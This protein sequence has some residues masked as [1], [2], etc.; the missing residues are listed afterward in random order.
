[1]KR[2]LAVLFTVLLVCGFVSAQETEY[3]SSSEGLQIAP[4]LTF[5]I[6]G[7]EPN[8]IIGKNHFESRFGLAV[9][10]GSGSEDYGTYS[11]PFFDGYSYSD[12]GE[13][14]SFVAMVTPKIQIGFNFEGYDTGWQDV[15][16]LAYASAFAFFDDATFENME[17]LALYYR[18]GIR[19]K[20]GF[21]IGF[22]TYLPFV[23]CVIG[24]EH[25]SITTVGQ[26]SGFIECMGAGLTVT[27]LDLKWYF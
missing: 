23:Y 11:R 27:S 2:A 4:G 3:Y 18:G 22:T 25:F 10:A 24:P 16:G 17:A 9:A 5:S 8:V 26:A 6:F 7:V 19:L 14:G 1:M 13:T 12:D 21:E 20:V 15:L